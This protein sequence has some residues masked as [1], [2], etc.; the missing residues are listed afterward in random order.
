MSILS[1]LENESIFII[2][3]AYAKTKE[4]A[5]LWSM[6]KDS[7]VLFLQLACTANN[8]NTTCSGTI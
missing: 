2:R 3:E 7:T 1:D 5:L 6:G 4:L 8:R